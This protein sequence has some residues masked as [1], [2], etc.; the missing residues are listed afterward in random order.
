MSVALIATA[1]SPAGSVTVAERNA[2]IG[3]ISVAFDSINDAWRRAD[4]PAVGRTML[5]EGLTTD[6]G[7]RSSNAAARAR[8]AKN[9]TGGLAG[10]YISRYTPR[11]DVLAPDVAVTSSENDFARIGLGKSQGPMQVALMTIVW[12]RTD[13][14]WRML[15]YH[16]S[17]RP[18]DLKPPA[19]LLSPYTGKYVKADGSTV[20]FTVVDGAL[21]VT[22]GGGATMAL[23]AFTEPNFG[24]RNGLRVTFVRNR[25]R[26]FHGVLL[27]SPDGSSSYA[28]R[29]K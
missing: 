6:N 25:D 26:T 19:Q 12:K 15:Y 2:A 1:C 4:F 20:Q 11:Y 16:E 14:G 13:G 28:W 24:R 23:E 21:N 27:M 10:Q 7:N 17:T 18:K 29:A 5:D 9:P 22:L 8:A 3:Q